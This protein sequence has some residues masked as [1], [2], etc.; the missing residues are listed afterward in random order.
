M[1]ARYVPRNAFSVWHDPSYDVIG[2]MLGG[3][4]SWNFQ[5]GRKK[6]GRKA[7]KNGGNPTVNKKDIPEKPQGGLHQPPPLTCAGEG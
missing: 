4:G 3:S 6:D 7:I 1:F 2:Q 5:G